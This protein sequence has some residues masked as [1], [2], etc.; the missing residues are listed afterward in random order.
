[1]SHSRGE[2]TAEDRPFEEQWTGSHSALIFLIF[3]HT[4][5]PLAVRGHARPN[6]LHGVQ[7]VRQLNS[8]ISARLRSRDAHCLTYREAQQDRVFRRIL[9]G[10]G[11]SDSRVVSEDFHLTILTQVF[12][13][14][15]V[16]KYCR[17]VDHGSTRW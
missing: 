13:S 17:G 2:Q 12:A 8:T 9:D 5:K 10:I 3:R 15:I 14:H 4:G 11:R 16:N 1:M 7:P 6:T